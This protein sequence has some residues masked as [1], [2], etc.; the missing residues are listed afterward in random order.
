MVKAQQPGDYDVNNAAD[1]DVNSAADDDLLPDGW[2]KRESCKKPGIFAYIHSESGARS[3]RKPTASTEEKI[4]DKWA[5][6]QR[7]KSKG[8]SSAVGVDVGVGADNE[9]GALKLEPT[10]K[11]RFD[12][13]LDL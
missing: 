12:R 3:S 1:D 7:R 13:C 8:T 5:M 10:T 4:I 6:K 2:I 11:G 9:G